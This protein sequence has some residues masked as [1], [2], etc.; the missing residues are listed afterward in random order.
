MSIVLQKVN[1]K[2]AAAH[3]CVRRSLRYT[4]MTMLVAATCVLSLVEGAQGAIVQF[5]SPVTATSGVVRLGDVAEVRGADPRLMAQLEAIEICPAPASGRNRRLDFDTIRARLTARGI[6]LAELEFSG[7]SVILV[8]GPDEVLNPSGIQQ[9]SGVTL[10]DTAQQRAQKVLEQAVA[11]FV[12]QQAPQV[13]SLQIRMRLTADQSSQLLTSVNSRLQVAGGRSPWIGLQEFVVRTVDNRG[14]DRQFNI[15]CFVNP[16][17]QVPVARFTIAK[18]QVLKEEDLGW[19]QV[20]KAGDL[21]GA[22]TNLQG[23][24]GQETRRSLRPGKPITPQDI[25]GVPMIR[26]GELISVY[27][28][29]G[30]VVAQTTAKAVGDGSYGELIQAQSIG[31][32]DRLVVRVAGY[33]KA[34][35]VTSEDIIR[36]E[37]QATAQVQAEEAS[38]E[39]PQP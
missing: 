19:Q 14:N 38:S 27:S 21:E 37:Q 34:F 7:D 5:R 3:G 1:L 22:I 24:V 31:G 26:T 23:L 11:K 16:L 32:R 4:R 20:E 33:H 17:P 9:V 2:L 13:G 30:A 8:N 12:R 10:S 36:R 25:R 15:R 6:S 28:Q 39:S 18:G 35:V 29:V